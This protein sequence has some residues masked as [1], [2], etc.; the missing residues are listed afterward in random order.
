M[1]FERIS[2]CKR[3]LCYSQLAL[4]KVLPC[5]QQLVHLAGQE[6][7]ASYLTGRKQESGGGAGAGAADGATDA[8]EG[9]AS[10]ASWS[11]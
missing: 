9:A 2:R 5:L 4:R 7:T 8:A 10:H 6:P 1:Q 11:V 3:P